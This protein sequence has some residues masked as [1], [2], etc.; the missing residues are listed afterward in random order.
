[1]LPNYDGRRAKTVQIES[2][3][4]LCLPVGHATAAIT[5]DGNSVSGRASQVRANRLRWQCGGPPD[6][7]PYYQMPPHE[8]V[9]GCILV[10]L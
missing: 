2:Q 5:S 10:F 7:Q 8:T 3:P 4:E 9:E 1:M 6:G